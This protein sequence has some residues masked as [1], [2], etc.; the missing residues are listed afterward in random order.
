MRVLL[1]EGRKLRVEG[2][3]AIY[4]K[5]GVLEVLGKAIKPRERVSVPKSKVIFV[6]ALSDTVLEVE[7]G[8][9]GKCDEIE[10][11]ATPVEWRAVADEIAKINPPLKILIIGGVDVGKTIFVT[12]L[13]NLLTSKGRRVIVIDEDLGQSEIGAPTTIG[14][15]LFTKPVAALSKG[16]RIGGFFVGKTSPSGVIH[17]VL[18]G[19]KTLLE[20]AGKFK[21]DYI[22]INT[23]GWIYGKEAKELKIGI[24]MMLKPQMIVAIQ[25]DIETEPIISAFTTQRWVRIV[26]LI[27]PPV[28]KPRSLEDRRL[29]R[30]AMYHRNLINGRTIKL[31]FTKIS[32]V[33]ADLGTVFRVPEDKARKI[34]DYLGVN[35]KY[36]GHNKEKIL[37]VVSRH[38]KR[39]VFKEALTKLRDELDTD[40]RVL[41]EGD[42]RGL[43]VGLYDYMGRFLGIGV[44]QEIDYEEGFMKVFT[45]VKEEIGM[46]QF[47]SVRLN[48]NFEEVSKLDTWPL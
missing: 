32:L 45:A 44:V 34:T 24:A 26:R 23:D 4:V 29:L 28:I 14:M 35:P 27:A 41:G 25:R 47:G 7:L 48:E 11:P 12:Y 13:V 5:D 8:D 39:R 16:R 42:E 37:V 2:P 3:A 20:E 46:V 40:V 22:I 18:I 9:E 15:A 43:V 17:R 10:E 19:L 33:F 31:P 6:S 36:L 21:P 38:D 1:K 30:E